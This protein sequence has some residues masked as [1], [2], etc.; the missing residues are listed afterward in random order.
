VGFDWPDLSGV[1]DKIEE[2]LSEVREAIAAGRNEEVCEEIGDLLFSIVNLG[3]YR[4]LNAEQALDGTVRKFI[5]RFQ[6]IEARLQAEGKDLS[7]CSL[8][9]L[10]AHWESV[11][12]AERAAR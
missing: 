6:A 1:L 8:A 5:T 9:E 3:R 2:E 4:K 7:A 11:K 12:A 10:D